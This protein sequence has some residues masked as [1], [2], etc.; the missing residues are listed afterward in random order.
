M[1]KMLTGKLKEGKFSWKTE[2]IMLFDRQNNRLE[3]NV[4][5]SFA[6]IEY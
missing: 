2:G 5:V 4:K 6:H 1:H 3:D